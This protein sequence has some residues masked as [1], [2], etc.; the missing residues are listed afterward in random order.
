MV[1]L[2][3]KI[4]ASQTYDAKLKIKGHETECYSPRYIK[5]TY[6][7]GGCRVLGEVTGDKVKKKIGSIKMGHQ[8]LDVGTPG[9]QSKLLWRTAGYL[10]VSDDEYIAVLKSRAPFLV[11]LLALL[12]AMIVLLMLLKP[13]S[14][15][16]NGGLIVIDPDH[17]LPPVDQNQSLIEGDDSQKANVEQGGGSISLVFKLDAKLD[18]STGD[19]TISYQNPNSSTHNI[20]LDMYIVSGGQEYLIARSGLLEPGYGLT[21]MELLEDAPTLSEGIYEGLFRVHSFDPITGEQA[22]VIPE[23]PGLIITVVNGTNS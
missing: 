14:T 1:R 17:P 4:R 11:I 13:G 5:S 20:I 15:P 10:Q 19:I 6:P 21:A 16:D 18:L 9:G 23:M 8:Q 22:V 2:E 3:I 7:S 12:T